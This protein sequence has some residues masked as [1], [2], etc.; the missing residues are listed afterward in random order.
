M[1]RIVEEHG[2]VPVPFELDVD[3]MHPVEPE[4]LQELITDKVL[5]YFVN[6]IYY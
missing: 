5:F 6:S 3:T 4:K 1:Y 2:L